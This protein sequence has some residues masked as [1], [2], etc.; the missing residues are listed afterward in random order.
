[1]MLGDDVTGRAVTD[2][3][4]LRA[5]DAFLLKLASGY[6]V[7]AAVAEAAM[8]RMW[9]YR[10]RESDPDFAALWDEAVDAG[11]DVLEDEARRRAHDGV[12]EPIVAMGKVAKD[13]DGNILKVR[14]Y[15]DGLLTLLLKARRPD[16]FKDRATVDTNVT[17]QVEHKHTADE[18]YT[19]F[20]SH[21]GLAA[22][23]PA[24][25]LG[26]DGRVEGEGPAEPTHT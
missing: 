3:T 24:G 14:R 19:A 11:T 16:R 22:A 17:G 23:R 5:R 8:S 4:R 13:E 26:D 9:F 1:M 20:L 2:V 12:E 25:L 7:T 21:V 6:S 10:E 18:A 15:S